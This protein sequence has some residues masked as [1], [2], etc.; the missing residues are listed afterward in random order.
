MIAP[1]EGGVEPAPGADKM[2]RSAKSAADALGNRG[3]FH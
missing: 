2:E 3:G 1:G